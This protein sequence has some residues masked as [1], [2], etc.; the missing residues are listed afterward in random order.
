[1]LLQDIHRIAFFVLVMNKTLF[2]Q[3]LIN[4]NAYTHIWE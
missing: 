4:I 2:K 1:M 3:I